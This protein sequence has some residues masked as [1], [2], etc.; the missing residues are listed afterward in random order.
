MTKRFDYLQRM[1]VLAHALNSVIDSDEFVS[2]VERIRKNTS[3]TK[4]TKCGLNFTK[5]MTD[6]IYD[7]KENAQQILEHLNFVAEQERLL[8]PYE[9]SLRILSLNDCKS[10]D[11]AVL[12]QRNWQSTV[13]YNELL[14]NKVL[15]NASDEKALPECE[16]ISKDDEAH[17]L[18][19][20]LACI[21]ATL[22]AV[23]CLAE[24]IN[25]YFDEINRI[26]EEALLYSPVKVYVHDINDKRSHIYRHL[27]DHLDKTSHY[28]INAKVLF[29]LK[30][31][32][33]KDRSLLELV[34]YDYVFKPKP[35]F[36]QLPS[37]IT[38]IDKS[39]CKKVLFQR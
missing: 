21:I 2:S 7:L 34:N 6:S 25:D 12:S 16:D 32:I 4:D 23:W 11:F 3:H 22:N 13:Y 29:R 38:F 26:I 10:I 36:G 24:Q 18:M 9:C 8:Y 14:K 20:A 17:E 30:H 35:V 37:Q 1:L 19:N 15:I 5:K 33:Y 28:F 31:D 39:G 27:F